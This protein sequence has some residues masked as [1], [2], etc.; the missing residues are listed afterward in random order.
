[1]HI[2]DICQKTW[3]VTMSVINLFWWTH[4]LNCSLIIAYFFGYAMVDFQTIK[5]VDH[6]RDIG[7]IYIS[8]T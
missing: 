5:K 8:N 7:L 2:V 6:M 4:F 1:M 3:S